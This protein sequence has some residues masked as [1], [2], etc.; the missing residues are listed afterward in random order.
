MIRKDYLMRILKQFFEFIEKLIEIKQKKK[1]DEVRTYLN[2]IY[3]T[4]LNH[5]AE[6]YLQLSREEI[7]NAFEEEEREIKMEMLAELLYQDGLLDSGLAK[8]EKSLN[9]YDYLQKHSNT[10]SFNR[11]QRIEELKYLIDSHN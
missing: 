2:E 4:Y 9:L 10:Y 5:S 3:E 8:L 11:V 7:I 6:Y 1:P